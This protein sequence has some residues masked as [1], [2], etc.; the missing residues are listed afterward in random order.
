MSRLFTKKKNPL[1]EFT[2]SIVIL[3]SIAAA[4]LYEL[5]LYP[6]GLEWTLLAKGLPVT[7]LGLYVLLNIRTV[8]HIILALALFASAVG[9]IALKLP[10]EDSFLRG[11]IAFGTAHF[12]FMVLFIRNRRSAYL[13]TRLRM[14]LASLVWVLATVMAIILYQKLDRIDWAVFSYMIAL[15]GMVSSAQISRYP[16]MLVG[17]GPLLFLLSDILIA[18]DQFDLVDPMPWAASVIWITYYL[19]QFF[20]T[21]GVLI[22][23][24]RERR[25]HMSSFT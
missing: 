25:Y 9:D 10:T 1:L 3:L 19:A 13:I 18:L 15:A 8:D 11:M 4:V 5:K 17:I 7:L 12:F 24:D 2:G 21:V 23:P 20:I 14:N 22:A 16:F 6:E